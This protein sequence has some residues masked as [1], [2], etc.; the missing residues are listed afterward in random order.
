MRQQ[1]ALKL[2]ERFFVEDHIVQVSRGDTRQPKAVIDGLCGKAMIEFNATEAFFLSRSHEVT[3][4][5][6]GCSRVMVESRNP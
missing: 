6:Q 2:L 1:D 3:I 5:Q 4:T